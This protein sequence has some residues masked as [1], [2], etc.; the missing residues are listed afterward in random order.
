MYLMRPVMAGKCSLHDLR[1]IYTIDDLADFHEMIDLEESI[2]A[3]QREEAE[4]A[5]KRR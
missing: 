4:R 3:K 5:R 1:T 2:H